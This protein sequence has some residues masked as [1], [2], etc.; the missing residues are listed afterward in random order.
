M[1]K[2]AFHEQ[3]LLRRTS[4]LVYKPEK[5][6]REGRVTHATTSSRG[7]TTRSSTRSLYNGICLMVQKQVNIIRQMDPRGP[8]R[9]EMAD[10]LLDKLRRLATVMTKINM[11]EHLK[12][13]VTY[14]E[15][16]HVRVGL[17]VVT[18]PAFLV[19]RNMEDFITWVDSSKIKKK[20]M[21]YNDALDDYDVM[22]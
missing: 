11:A 20:V 8:F 18:D 17:E 3:K 15:Q 13:A 5:G 22:A 21:E 1:R 14:I 4:F 2:L 6:H 12:E 7:T 19:T 16:G 10:M 9:I